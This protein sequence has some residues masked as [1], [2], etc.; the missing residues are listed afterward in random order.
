[1]PDWLVPLD[2]ATRRAPGVG[3]V[4]RARELER[5]VVVPALI[6]VVAVR[7]GGELVDVDVLLVAGVRRGDL[8]PAVA[9][10]DGREVV[11]GGA[12]VGGAVDPDVAERG[13]SRRGRRCRR[14]VPF[15]DQSI[16]GSQQVLPCGRAA[17]CVQVEPPLV[18]YHMIWPEPG[19]L[20]AGD[21]LV[22]VGRVDLHRR[23]GAAGGRGDAHVGGERL[24]VLEL[25]PRRCRAPG[26][27]RSGR[28]A[29]RLRVELAVDQVAAVAQLEDLQGAARVLGHA[30]ARH[31]GV[32][33]AQL[34][35]EEDRDRVA[36]LVLVGGE[37][38]EVVAVTR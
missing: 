22:D 18:E 3:E 31:V 1:M 17:A 29:H 5:V 12:A 24:G 32:R 36:Q 21:H 38:G 34:D 8:A 37:Q 10:S 4:G 15:E 20:R 35:A 25:L 19:P 33:L 23:L 27:P 9:G 13:R 14:T 30:G 6:D 26:P 11:P 7:R 16:V 2:I 28:C